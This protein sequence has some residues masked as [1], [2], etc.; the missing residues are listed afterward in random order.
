MKSMKLFFKDFH[1]VSKE[2]FIVTDYLGH[3]VRDFFDKV[4]VVLTAHSFRVLTIV[5]ED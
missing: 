1:L 2:C 5:K 4:Q 3:F